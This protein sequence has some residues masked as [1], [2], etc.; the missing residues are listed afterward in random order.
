MV[1]SKVRVRRVTVPSS[2][3]A[4]KLDS[5]QQE[6][7]GEEDQTILEKEQL[8]RATEISFPHGR[9]RKTAT[10]TRPRG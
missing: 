5:P 1:K 6:D 7:E 3:V 4:G 9:R 2:F 8:S 10:T